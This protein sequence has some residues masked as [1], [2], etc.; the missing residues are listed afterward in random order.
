[1]YLPRHFK[2]TDRDQSLALVRAHPLATVISVNDDGGPFVSHLPLVVEQ[3]SDL[4]NATGAGGVSSA[5][6]ES[7]R[8]DGDVRP[9]LSGTTGSTRRPAS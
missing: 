5:C 9:P 6:I 7:S 8:S 1:V 2:N 4:R 3:N